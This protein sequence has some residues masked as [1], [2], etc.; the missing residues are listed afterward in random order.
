[1]NNDYVVVKSF[2]AFTRPGP[3]MKYEKILMIP[4]KT[5][6]LHGLTFNRIQYTNL[7][8]EIG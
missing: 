2:K 3:T 7:M 5:D 6:T 4:V 8:E 1:M